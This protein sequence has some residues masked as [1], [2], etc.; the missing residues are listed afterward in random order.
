MKL[1]TALRYVIAALAGAAIVL[2]VIFAKGILQAGSATATFKILSDAFLASGLAL[3]LSGA[4]V[5]IVRQGT[6]S[7]LGYAFS[8]LFVALHD[9]QYRDEHK[10]T[11]LE[12]GERKAAKKPP[13]LFLIIVG[14]A[15]L[16][17]SITF[18]ILFYVV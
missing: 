18:T 12:Y 11:Y 5:W 2:S 16:V 1:R 8:R 14:A 15:Y 3:T 6:F 9:K 17:P 7:G 4:F 13:F 10:E